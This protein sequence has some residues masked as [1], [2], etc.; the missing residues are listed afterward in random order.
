MS[1]G[2]CSATI[3]VGVMLWCV[4]GA[5]ASWAELTEEEFTNSIGMKFVHIKPG[6]FLMGTPEEDVL[7][8]ALTTDLVKEKTGPM[9]H[10]RHG[11]FDEHPV[12]EVRIT[13]PFF[14]AAM[15]VTNA[16]YEQYDFN[17]GRFR[18]QQGFSCMD[19]EAVIFVMWHDAVAFC[20][21]LSEKEGLPYRLP[22]EAEWEYAC[23]AGTTTPFS[24]GDALPVE[25]QKNVFESWHPDPT[26]TRI[27]EKFRYPERQF[28]DNIVLLTVGR[29]P[30]NPWGLYDMHGNVEEWCLDWYGPYVSGPQ[31]DPVGRAEGEFRVTR[32]G[33]HSTEL[34]FLRSANRMG[35]LPEDS[36]W[37]IGF[38]VVIGPMPNS[39]PLS[40]ATPYDYQKNVRTEVPPD[41]NQGPDR[42]KPYFKGPQPFVRISPE[43]H[44][45]LF[46]DHN[47]DPGLAPCPNGDLLTIWYTTSREK[48]RELCLAAS[49]LRYGAEEW[50]PASL[51]WLA[52]DRNLHSPSLWLDKESGLLYHFVGLSAAA[53]WGNLAAVMR[54]SRD[55]GASWSKARLIAPEHGLRHQMSEP[56]IRTRDG[57]L[58]VACDATGVSGTSFLISRDNGETWADSIGT[59]RGIHG[60]VVELRD[61]RLFG[62]GRG[63]NLD[64]HMPASYSSDQGWTWSYAPS[65][66]Q[67]I[68][69]GQRLV[70]LRLDEGPIMLVSFAQDV[71]MIDGSGKKNACSG[72]FVAL[73]FDEAETWPVMRLVTPGGAPRQT[74]TMD[75]QPFTLS[76]TSAEPRGY[77]AGC[78]GFNGVIHII[79]SFQHYAFNLAWIREGA[80]AT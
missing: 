44:G 80:N 77:L 13:E 41:R 26:P 75:N 57:A 17:H 3:G 8:D 25:F 61:G 21:W 2:A 38:R 9:P 11:D 37:L 51:F 18:G 69:G 71:P 36:S 24:M 73:S 78:Q 55:S 32:G 62:L 22:T 7:P 16:Q 47:H 46:I 15:E 27:T 40:P 63:N 5:A 28:K 72:M 19:D 74:G 66:F 70:L 12:H 29:T 56:V 30:P 67:P 23:R 79:S 45:P 1:R 14:M 4:I 68:S 39:K 60:G 53:T 20:E 31:A 33:S 64:D 10:R 43:A 34:Y 52:P 59:M 49:R 42:N 58:L 35:T 50:E 6:T 54:T 48:G 65:P 76:D